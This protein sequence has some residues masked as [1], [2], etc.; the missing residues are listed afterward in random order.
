MPTVV[1]LPLMRPCIK[2][3]YLVVALSFAS[4]RDAKI[5]LSE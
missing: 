5:V 1:K 2:S 4:S 3:L